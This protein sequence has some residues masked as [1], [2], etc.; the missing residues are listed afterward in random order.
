MVDVTSAETIHELAV[1]LLPGNELPPEYKASLYGSVTPFEEWVLLGSITQES[2]SKICLVRWKTQVGAGSDARV[3]VDGVEHK[4]GK[5][6]MLSWVKDK[7]LIIGRM[8]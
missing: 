8:T 2:P 7:V 1:F 3:S 6:L 4:M 5:T